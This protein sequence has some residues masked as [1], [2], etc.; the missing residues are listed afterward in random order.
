MTKIDPTISKRTIPNLLDAKDVKQILRVSLPTVYKM[1][2]RGQ[3]RCIR[4][5]CPGD[6]DEKP[7]TTLRFKAEDI[8]AFI[9]QH[10]N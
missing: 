10:Y 7:R 2:E 5:D 8:I 9:D 6:G 3:L 4:W 1:A